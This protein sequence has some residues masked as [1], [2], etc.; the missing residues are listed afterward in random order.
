MSK[1]LTYTIAEPA[2][3]Y[4]TLAQVGDMTNRGLAGGTVLI[5]VGRPEEKRSLSQNAKLWPM[6]T[7]I[8]EQVEWPV[9]GRMQRL[10]PE[11]WKAILS[12]GLDSEQRVAQGINGG[13]VM[14]GRSTS[15][16]KKAEFG[17][18]IEL[19]YMFGSER[20]IQWSEPALAI[21]EQYREVAA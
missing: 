9:N 12:A 6:L 14:L 3:I 5:T 4:P 1:S 17:D 20:G 11:D 7:D 13:F 18:L 8:A 16:M 19:I 21:Y 10:Q 15:R 2:D